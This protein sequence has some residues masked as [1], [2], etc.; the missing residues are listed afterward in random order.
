MVNTDWNV[1]KGM[2]VFLREKSGIFITELL[3]LGGM[4]LAD[5][6]HALSR[7]A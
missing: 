1:N 3:A 6:V 4:A 7:V 5:S 2:P